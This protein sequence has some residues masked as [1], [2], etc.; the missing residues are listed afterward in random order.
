MKRIFL[1][2]LIATSIVISYPSLAV[3]EKTTESIETEEV[4]AERLCQDNTTCQERLRQ[5]I[6]ENNRTPATDSE[7]CYV[8]FHLKTPYCNE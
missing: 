4:K 8:Y 3:E 2:L 1:H 7:N 6:S 5:F